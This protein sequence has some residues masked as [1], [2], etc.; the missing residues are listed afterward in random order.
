M[1]RRAAALVFGLL[2][3]WL[4]PS[5]AESWRD[6]AVMP[7]EPANPGSEIP[8]Q[9]LS[10][11]LVQDGAGFLWGGSETGLLRWDG[12][13]FRR[14]CAG[15][16]E[17]FGLNDCF[18]QTLLTGRD[19]TLWVGTASGGLAR[20]DPASDRFDTVPLGDDGPQTRNVSAMAGDGAEG[21]WVATSGGLFHLD[22]AGRQLAWLRHDSDLPDSLPE[23][24]I[25]AL[26]ID[27]HGQI[28][29]GGS[30]GLSRAS[31]SGD[32]F[33][34]VTLDRKSPAE[35]CHLME[36]SAGRI[37][38]GTR[39][40]GAYVILPSSDVRHIEPLGKV[41]D[42]E[43]G[44]EV[45]T[46]AEVRGRIWLGTFGEGIIEVEDGGASLRHIVH[47]PNV[48]SSL[49]S[50]TVYAL[51][52][53]RSGL[54]WVSTTHGLSHANPQNA[55]SLIALHGHPEGT[56]GLSVGDA[57]SVL[58]RPDG[59]IWVSSEHDG[60]D[61]LKPDLR[62]VGHLP[63][64][65]VFTMAQAPDGRVF[66]GTR[67]SL[68]AVDGAGDS[69]LRLVVPNRRESEP[70]FA[71]LVQD[72]VVWVGGQDDGLYALRVGA[73]GEVTVLRHMMAPMLT[74][75]WVRQ[76][77]ATP[78]GRLAVATDGGISFVA[79]L[80]GSV[81]RIA[82]GQADGLSSAHPVS[83]AF[84]AG[85]RL[86]VGHDN[87]GIDVIALRDG[88]FA[89][90]VRHL[91]LAD[92]LPN[93]DVNALVTDRTGH[94]WLS[95][96]NGIASVDE[97]SFAVRAFGRADGL[98][99]MGFWNDS[100]ASLPDGS[101]LF[102]GVEGLARVRPDAVKDWTYTP[103]LAVTEL[104]IGGEKTAPGSLGRLGDSPSLTVPAYAQ[105]FAI[106]FASLDFSAPWLN[107]YRYRLLGFDSHW[108][109][110]DSAH[111]MAAYT[112]IAPGDYVL[113]VQG[114]NRNKIFSPSVT[115]I[116]VHVLPAW[117]QTMW[118]HAV[119]A[120]LALGVVVGVAQART[121]LLRARQR[122]LERQV[123]ERTAALSASERQLHQLAYFDALT[124]L[125]NRRAFNKA[126]REALEHP[127]LK[128]FALALVDLDGFKGVNDTL[129]HDAGDELL[130]LAASRLRDAIREG[131]F[132][133]RLGGDEFAILLM[134]VGVA[135]RASAIC[136][137]VVTSMAQPMSLRSGEATIGASVG[138]ALFPMHATDG[139][140]LYRHADHALYEA[141]RNGRGK[142]RW[143]EAGVAG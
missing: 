32:D 45:R 114:T 109:D 90:L 120:V 112:N 80:N 113:E 85:G 98:D 19:G 91:G 38:A 11:A 16:G 139:E 72:G 52:R 57:T 48:T 63:I 117:F 118:F 96:D 31:A 33:T 17:R 35:V 66:I 138:V 28:W 86:W 69:V 106:E 54:V 111:R 116:A 94:M 43:S 99:L 84:D 97:R 75:N 87:A 133:A 58:I 121:I 53:D 25:Q 127:T 12:N 105:G 44:T 26:M 62:R 42:G 70:A 2:G 137:R 56:L 131:D 18:V 122:E 123:A 78:D 83:L 65:R 15:P 27:H 13:R 125:P 124:A 135:N 30:G 104:R 101:I 9:V 20:Y 128:D 23:F 50:N 107:L 64:R 82:A 41:E 7:F 93:L 55:D 59:T 81:T 10:A 71:V 34:N 95:T 79:G 110:V 103:P 100:A 77:T 46:I 108:I 40:E 49:D 5:H 136:E 29:V 74:G 22:Q 132:V 8:S 51:Y 47:D 37:W 142:W 88:R 67:G 130:L 14:Y 1:W 61:I 21:F 126:F 36:D 4:T 134:G 24:Q 60:V 143:F 3:F 115:R 73:L 140:E 119:Q 141:K 92:G 68:L 89:R 39:H 6:A 76:I 129:G 102:G